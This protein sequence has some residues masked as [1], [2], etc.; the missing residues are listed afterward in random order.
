MPGRG[1]PN[2]IHSKQYQKRATMYHG[3]SVETLETRGGDVA[4]RRHMKP[5]QATS[6]DWRFSQLVSMTDTFVHS[7]QLQRT[8]AD[9]SVHTF[10]PQRPKQD[11]P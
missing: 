7:S 2:S 9:G 8:I 1:L 4:L 5:K 6:W 3:D 11:I 10:H